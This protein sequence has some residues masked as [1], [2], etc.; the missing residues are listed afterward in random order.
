MSEK[1]YED[2]I[3]LDYVRLK[4]AGMSP[5][6]LV[7]VAAQTDA[8]RK[9][10]EDSAF[11]DIRKKALRM[12]SIIDSISAGDPVKISYASLSVAV[13]GLSYL[14]K[15]IDLVPDMIEGEGYKDD[16]IVL[17]RCAEQM[18]RELKHWKVKG[19]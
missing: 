8:I 1:S 9:T 7:S 3:T 14:V 4:A 10:L 13:F 11:D 6:D 2:L 16:A 12:V 17:A 5:N 15:Q 19:D 18:G